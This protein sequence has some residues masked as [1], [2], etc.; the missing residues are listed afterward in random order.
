[1]NLGPAASRQLAR[2]IVAGSRTSNCK[3]WLTP[4]AHSLQTVAQEIKGTALEVGSQN[5]HWASSGAFTG[6]LSVPMLKECGC[7]YAIVGHS[8]RR[9]MLGENNEQVAKR[10][11][12][13]LEQDF[14]IILCIGETLDD[15]EHGLT[16]Q[17]LEKQLYPVLSVM[18][19][20]WAD[21]LVIAYE[22]VW[23]IGTGKVADNA[24]ITDAHN[25]IAAQ[26][27]TYDVDSD[28]SVPILYGGSVSPDNFPEIA[29]LPNVNG[30]LVGGASLKADQFLKL[31]DC[32][33]N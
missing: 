8:E 32:Y 33:P 6:E 13:A 1:M 22:P 29:K 2:D 4:S 16:N 14:K 9:H 5:V 27:S 12:C 17:V 7:T 3:I 15:R 18:Q 21:N 26:L 20:S 19:G 30:A 23:A 11:L 28:N 10:C 24:Q 25:F 31:V